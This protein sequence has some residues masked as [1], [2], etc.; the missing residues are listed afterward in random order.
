MQRLN[1]SKYLPSLAIA[2]NIEKF[3]PVP[4]KLLTGPS[5][6]LFRGYAFFFLKFAAF[7]NS[8]SGLY[9]QTQW[10][11]NVTII[12]MAIESRRQKSNKVDDWDRCY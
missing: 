9:S 1:R 10:R 11:R 12:V 6:V 5:K 3:G 2:L 7:C 4:D 8:S